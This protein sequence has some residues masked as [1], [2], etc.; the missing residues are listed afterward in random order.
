MAI[1]HGLESS[2]VLTGPGFLDGSASTGEAEENSGEAGM[3]TLLGPTD[4]EGSSVPSEGDGNFSVPLR[5]GGQLA[6]EGQ[7]Q[8]GGEQIILRAPD[9][10]VQLKITVT[11]DGPL[12][13]FRAAALQLESEGAL[14][15]DCEDLEIRARG[16]IDQQA[17]GDLV[18]LAKGDLNIRADRC[19][20][21]ARRGDVRVWA[22]DDVRLNGERVKLNC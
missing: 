11:E 1:V 3:A 16:N 10:E 9:G 12:L 5:F 19:H 4:P 15:V 6:V 8:E 21:S 7:N 18:Q 14:R 2:S 20:M 17:N 13:H 22:N